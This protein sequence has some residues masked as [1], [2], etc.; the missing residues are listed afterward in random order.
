M[1]Q[2]Q[3]VSIEIFP[4]LIQK[5]KIVE[6]TKKKCHGEITIEVQYIKVCGRFII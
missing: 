2:K 1:T 5:Y 3:M 6:R 4:Y